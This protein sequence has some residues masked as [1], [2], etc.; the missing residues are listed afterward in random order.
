M[1]LTAGS[2]IGPYEIVAPLGAG[3]MGEVWRARD[4][5]LGREVAIKSLPAAF[6]RIGNGSRASSARLGSS[7]GSSTP[8]H[9]DRPRPRGFRRPAVPRHG[10]RPGTSPWR[11]GSRPGRSRCGKPWRWRGRWRRVSSPRTR[12]GIVHRDLK[13]ANVKMAPDGAVKLLDFG[14]AKAFDAIF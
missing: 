4:A 8:V 13:P 7:P 1:S 12:R 10:A 9:R 14:L 6:A 11:T 3:G 5:R 2:R